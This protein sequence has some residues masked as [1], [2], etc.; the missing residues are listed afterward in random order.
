MVRYVVKPNDT[1]YRL[2]RAFIVDQRTWMALLPL[3]GV[4]DPHRLPIGRTLVI[5]RDWLRA[6]TEDASLVSFRGDVTIRAGGRT[7]TPSEGLAIHEGTRIVTGADGFATLTLAD[8]SRISL[9]SQSDVVF[10]HL[11]RL[12]L[13]GAVEYQMEVD[14][15]RLQTK[16]TPLTDPSGRYRIGTP[17][18]MTAVR[19]TEFRV[20]FD[21]KDATAA[22]E[23]LAGTVAVATP[24]A[25]APT[26]VPHGFG[27]AADA[28]GHLKTEEL[29]PPPDLADSD[30]PQTGEAVVFHLTPVPGAAAYHVALASDAG[31]VD[32]YMERRSV[33]PDI[34]LTG[35]P[36]GKGFVRVSA[37]AP[38]GL[39]GIPRTYPLLRHLVTI[40]AIGTSVGEDGFHFRW[41]GDGTGTRRYRFQLLAWTPYGTP[42]S[43]QVGL[44]QEEAVVRR[45][46]PAIYYWRVGVIQSTGDGD[47]QSWTDWQRMTIGGPYRRYFGF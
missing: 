15:G 23:V 39:E 33:S 37:I 8:R 31:F 46:K 26:A 44:A 19:G 32:T 7:V 45:L 27:A 16:V 18:T 11:R 10:T 30:R 41:T 9:P 25:K 20:G 35:V 38:S 36:E 1:L 29:L 40:R 34:T 42:V 12:V 4:R 17:L 5:P 2:A 47:A 28:V 14:K 43:D 13:T 21:P 6:N 22:A 3:A 24:A